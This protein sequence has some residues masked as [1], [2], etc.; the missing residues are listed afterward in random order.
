MSTV[1]DPA[2]DT[3]VILFALATEKFVAG[4]DP[5]ITCVAPVKAEPL[6][7][8][9]VPPVA[10]PPTGLIEATAGTA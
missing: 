3:A 2:G 4:V 6:I 1:P 10:G 8:T 9:V 5:N 7:V